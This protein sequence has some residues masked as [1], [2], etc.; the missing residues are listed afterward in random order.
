MATKRVGLVSARKKAGYT[1][2]ALA[3]ALNVD[4][5]TV[6]RWESG[7]TEPLPHQR[8]KLVRL[9]CISGERLAE[10]LA[11]P[12]KPPVL[13]GVQRGEAPGEEVASDPVKRR[14]LMQWGVTTAAATG[15]GIEVV[16]KIGMANVQ[17]LQ[18]ATDRL[19]VLDHR[20]GGESLWQ[21]GVISVYEANVMLEH[22]NY[23]ASVGQALLVAT[24][25]LQIRTGWLACDAGRQ[26]VARSSFTDALTMARQA[27]DLEIEAR[28]LAGLGFQSN[29]VSRPR[30]G[31]RFS[32]AAEVAVNA[33]GPLSRMAA[34]P[35]LHL[36]VAN[37]RS[38]DHRAAKSAIARARKA[39]DADQGHQTANWAAF[40]SPMEI[41]AVEATC[42]VEAGKATRAEKLL[43]QAIAGYGDGFTRNVALYRVRLTSARVK[44][45]AVDGAIETADDVLDAIAEGLDSWRVNLELSRVMQA[46]STHAAPGVDDLLERY[47]A[48]VAV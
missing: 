28:A 11:Q 6:G 10:H 27:G 16:G 12:H 40:M 32:Q 18:R 8:P 7:A 33:L 17:R 37:A 2:E 44:S 25:N 34:V 43:E 15:F 46:I 38:N 22:A 9:L 36:A 14:T 47:A 1:Q 21:A 24:G 45:G 3:H 26:D 42:A 30:E 39:L 13:S 19:C 35:L 41:D 48:V 4:P 23:S 5:S 20:H 29:L 31:L